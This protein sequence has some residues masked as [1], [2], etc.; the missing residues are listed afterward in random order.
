V[1]GSLTTF[2]GD[3]YSVDYPIEWRV[4]AADQW[5]GSYYDTTIRSQV[6]PGLML[7]VDIS[8]N[9]PPSLD[10]AARPVVRALERQSG[11]QLIAYEPFLFK[12]HDAIYWEF[13]VLED[14]RLLRKVDVFFFDSYGRGYGLLTQAPADQWDAWSNRMAQLRDSLVIYG[15]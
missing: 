15:D 3:S 14:G 1:A 5:K 13:L 7:R 6:D 12:G 11:Y 2:S 9:A 10:A 4:E 8:P